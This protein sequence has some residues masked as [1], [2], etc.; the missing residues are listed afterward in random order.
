MLVNW[1]ATKADIQNA[2][3]G[4][5]DP[6]EDADDVVLFYFSGHGEQDGNNRTICPYDTLP[7]SWANDIYDYQLNTW[8]G[9]LQSQRQVVVLDSCLSGGFITGAMGIKVA[10]GI[11]HEP[12]VSEVSNSFAKH[13]SKSGRVVMASCRDDESAYE[14][15]TFC[16]GV[17]SHYLLDGFGSLEAVD[18]D[19]NDKISAEELFGYVEPRTVSYV[20]L[21]IG[22]AQK[23]SCQ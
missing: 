20:S 7:D 12:Y 19:D 15:P 18:S 3:S 4:W 22:K 8:L 10:T 21:V 9:N 23:R 2:I 6:L 16:H 17:F 13:L 11:K 14:W 1:Q 5:L